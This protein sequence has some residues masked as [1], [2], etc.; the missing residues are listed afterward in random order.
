MRVGIA[1]DHGGFALKKRTQAKL[2]AAGCQSRFDRASALEN[3]K[4]E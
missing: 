4:R 1:T 3:S 2:S